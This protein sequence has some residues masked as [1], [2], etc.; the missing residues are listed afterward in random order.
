MELKEILTEISEKQ[1]KKIALHFALEKLF[2]I[3]NVE[4]QESKEVIDNWTKY[5]QKE[6]K[7]IELDE[8]ILTIEIP[9]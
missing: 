5:I 1:Y 9:D 4:S 2:E 7:P 3:K 6:L 8:D